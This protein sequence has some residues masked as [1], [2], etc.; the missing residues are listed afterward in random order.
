M[1][2]AEIRPYTEKTLARLAQYLI[3]RGYTANMV[4]LLGA[5][6]AV[7]A[8]LALMF[9]A[10][11]VALGFILIN[12]LCDGLDGVI[13]RHS[14]AG[15]T[16]FGGF[17][18]I[19]MDFIFYGGVVFFFSLG[20]PESAAIAVFLLF[21]I[22]GTGSSFLAYAAIAEK[23]GMAVK[24]RQGKAFFQAG[25]LMEGTETIIFFVLICLM[26]ESFSLLA[27]IFS[28]LCWVTT[29]NRISE[30]YRSFIPV[31]NPDESA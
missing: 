29:F 30:A 20:Q 13:A 27:L 23:R 8:F 24:K 10:Y 28:L 12:R 22:M 14:K 19:V 26:P 21:S 25:G 16:D 15:P 31:K 2:D 9:Q 4:T 3:V 11:S 17:L 1:L 7:P 18:D 6:M 5:A